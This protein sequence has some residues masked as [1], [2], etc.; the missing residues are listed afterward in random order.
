MENEASSESSLQL[1]EIT[2]QVKHP[3]IYPITK[4]YTLKELV[5]AAG[6]LT[7]SAYLGAAELSRVDFTDGLYK[8]KHQKVNLLSELETPRSEQLQ[9][10]SKDILNVVRIPQWYEENIV[11]L[12]GEFIFPG[13]YQIAEGE[14]LSS[15]IARAGGLTDNASPLAA[16][17]SREELKQ[18][19]RDNI[20]KT[21]EDLRQ[22]LANNNLSNSQFSKTIDYQNA[23][24]VLNDLSSAEPAGRMVIDIPAI[25]KGNMSAD[26]K[27]KNGDVL[28]IPNITPAISIIGEV[29]VAT[30]NMYDPDLDVNDYIQ[31]A[32]GI[33]EYG[34]QSKI[35]IV[36]A[37]GSIKV[38]ESNF[39]FTQ[40]D[41]NLLEPGDTIVV[42]RDVTNYDNISLWQGA[43]QILYQTAVALAAIGSL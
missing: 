15:V 16:V 9:I 40:S 26:I 38:P 41:K 32:G 2:G 6:G 10:Q 31:L 22:Q 8:I 17:F 3:G 13:R 43:T 12:R 7:E 27:V 18:R 24:T 39:W 11:E 19:E 35:Y 20:N 4:N 25:V 30:T 21:V 28:V 14:T 34:D 23:M 37:N 1:A 36:K 33:R 29:F 5:T 42:P